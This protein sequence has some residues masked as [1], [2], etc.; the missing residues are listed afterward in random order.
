MI[1]AL[2]A[3]L[4]LLAAPLAIRWARRRH[5]LSLEGEG[6]RIAVLGAMTFALAAALELGLGRALKAQL[7]SGG[8]P[9]EVAV[10]ALIGLAVALAHEPLRYATHHHFLPAE[11]RERHRASGLLYGLGYGGAMAGLAAL[12]L[13]VGIALELLGG[14][15]TRALGFGEGLAR[16]ADLRAT[17]AELEPWRPWLA[18]FDQL[19]WGIFQVGACLFV[20]R[21]SLL[22]PGLLV[23]LHGGLVAAVL[24]AAERSLQ[25]ETAAHGAAGFLGIALAILAWREGAG[26]GVSERSS[27]T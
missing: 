23:L 7:E 16:R 1:R 12:V 27:V 4:L 25:L 15:G 24:L 21:R 26:Q 2:P 19:L 13:L 6:A 18:A 9:G 17:F 3:L 8:A 10:A 5:R 14:E 20:G 11:P 22:R